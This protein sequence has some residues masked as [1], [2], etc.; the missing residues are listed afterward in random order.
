M[1]AACSEFVRLVET[2]ETMTFIPHSQKPTDRLASYYNPQ[3][4]LKIKNGVEVYRVRGTYGGNKSDYEGDVTAWT[5]DLSTVKMLLNSVIS[6]DSQWM[7]ADITD[8]YLG[9]PL[10]RPEYMRIHRKQIPQEIQ[11][12]YN[13]TS[14]WKDDQ[15][16]VKIVKGIYGLPQAGKLAQERLFKHLSEHGYYECPNTPCLFRHTTL[17]P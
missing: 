5:A 10:E 13:L 16:M 1:K 6:T 7:T 9:T 2:T 14:L 15:F 17:Q 8:F 3:I 11:T 4:K 12:K